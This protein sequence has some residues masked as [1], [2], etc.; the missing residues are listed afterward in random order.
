MFSN[1]GKHN[2]LITNLSELR[3][4]PE[5]MRKQCKA[6]P[7][8]PPNPRN[9]KAPLSRGFR[10]NFGGKPGI[11]TL[12]T[13][14]TFV[15]FQDWRAS[16]K[17]NEFDIDR[18]RILAFMT[19]LKPAQIKGC[20]LSCR[21]DSAPLPASCRTNKPS[22]LHPY[23]PNESPLATC[24]IGRQNFKNSKNRPT[25]NLFKTFHV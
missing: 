17:N 23:I 20:I 11:R 16:Q 15:G 13:L 12:G 8:P 19:G 24:S 18:F 9:T 21:N 3:K 25:L 22:F 5:I 14:L 2:L 7:R 6:L 1:T 10:M 4:P